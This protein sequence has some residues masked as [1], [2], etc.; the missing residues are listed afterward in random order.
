M[1]LWMLALNKWSFR[2]IQLTL[3]PP[4]GP[5]NLY[6]ESNSNLKKCQCKPE[7]LVFY[8]YTTLK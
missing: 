7:Y 6:M 5:P 3:A 1:Y 4:Q 2:H 8:F